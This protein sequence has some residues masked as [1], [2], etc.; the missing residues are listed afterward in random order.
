MFGMGS[1]DYNQVDLAGVNTGWAGTTG[2]VTDT[3][4]LKQDHPDGL[5]FMG[6][7]MSTELGRKFQ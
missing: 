7:V 3:C 5:L 6:D 2:S 4:Q 1:G